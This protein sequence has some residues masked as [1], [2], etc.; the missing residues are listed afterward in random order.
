MNS[1]RLDGLRAL[2]TAGGSGIGRVI[3]KCLIEAGAKVHICDVQAKLLEACRGEFPGL[4]TT[5]ADVSDDSAVDICLP[6]F[7]V[8]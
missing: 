3:A 6:M 2:I 1:L 4:V 5:V 7:R 8:T